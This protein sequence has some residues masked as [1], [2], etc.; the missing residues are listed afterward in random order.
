[1]A[2]KV[3]VKVKVRKRNLK[4]VNLDELGVNVYELSRKEISQY[5]SR[6]FSMANKR[7]KRLEQQGIFSPALHAIN[8]KEV[9]GHK[10]KF[11]AR[12]LSL[13]ELRSELKRCVNFLNMETSSL[14]GAK[15]YEKDLQDRLFGGKVLT[16]AQHKA[17]FEVYRGIERLSPVGVKAYG[18]DRLIQYLANEVTQEDEN[19]LR[20]ANIP[21]FEAFIDRIKNE[22]EKVVREAYITGI[23]KFYGELDDVLDL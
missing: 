7:I 18:S 22:A 19:L 6:Y 14:T 8:N 13:S 1:M 17:I 21:D 10:G 12:N 4:K 9:N 11:L 3:D 20:E 15:R 2:V 23:E 5:C 16:Q